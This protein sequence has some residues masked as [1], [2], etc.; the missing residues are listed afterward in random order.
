M[1][2]SELYERKKHG[3]SLFPIQLYR[4]DEKHP[5]YVMSAHWHNEFE[6][7][8][9]VKGEFIC[10]LNNISYHLAEGDILFVE[11][12]CLHRGIPQDC[13]YECIVF[14]LNMLL[15]NTG[16]TA[17]KYINPI[18]NSSVGVHCL[19]NH[20]NGSLYT[21]TLELFG[22]L[23]NKQSAYEL[24]VLSQ[25]FKIF[26]LLYSEEYIISHPKTMHSRQTKAVT[27]LLD[28]FENHLSEEITL[29]TLS[30]VSG[31]NKKYLCRIFKE[32]TS[33]TPITYLNELRIEHACYEMTLK[34]KNITESA[35]DSGF[36]DLSYFC[37][38][39]KKIKGITPKEYKKNYI[40]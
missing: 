35:F 37:K 19:L 31:L 26:S 25:L 13:I 36:N 20:N 39:F 7:I 24:D 11:C 14:D 38:S 2:Y 10:F 3:T 40:G 8:K 27:K 33:K 15:R 30:A 1:K 4:L 12:G 32:Y 23:K 6:I 9:V 22:V 29:D 18:I 21:A 16:D 28:W 34:S 5:Q 17:E